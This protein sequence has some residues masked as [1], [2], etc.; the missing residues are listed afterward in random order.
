MNRIPTLGT[1]A[2]PRPRTMFTTPSF[3]SGLQPQAPFARCACVCAGV[4]DECAADTARA[5]AESLAALDDAARVI[6][7]CDLPE[8]NGQAADLFRTTLRRLCAQME[9][10]AERC[11]AL[12]A[13]PLGGEA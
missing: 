8:W 5:A 1:R 11:R 2:L 13:R 9:D 6:A 10:A 3:G 7:S 4:L 12:G